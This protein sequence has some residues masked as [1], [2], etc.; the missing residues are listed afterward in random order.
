MNKS[1]KCSASQK[2]RI[3]I[4]LE[5]R[6]LRVYAEELTKYL[7][8]GWQ[9]GISEKHKCSLNKPHPTAVPWNKGLSKE[10]SVKVKDAASKVSESLKGKPSWNKG[11]TKEDERVR[12][13]AERSTATKISRYGKAFPNNNMNDEHKKKIGIALKGRPNKYRGCVRDPETG[14][15]ISKAKMGHTVSEETRAK[16]SLKKKGVKY[17]PEQRAIKASKEYLTRKKNNSFNTSS[18]EENLYNQ[19]LEEHSQ[20]TIL[21][22][23][24]DERYPFYCDF[25]IV[26]DDLFIEVNAHWTHG[27]RPYDP[28]DPECIAKLKEWEEKA[29]VSQFF[30]NAIIT[31]TVRDVKKL[32]TATKNNL[33]YKVIY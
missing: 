24:K 29:K 33:N 22:Q 9:I 17:S 8:C 23:Y 32:E 5:D 6:E 18:N 4:H 1:E 26:E 11:L 31:W 14:R 28:N 20:K 21:R 25:Y 15:K 13:N 30:R 2:G 10:T 19:L 3:V 27:G 7:S 12:V 16:I